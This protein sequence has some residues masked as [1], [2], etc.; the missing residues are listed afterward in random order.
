VLVV[1]VSAVV[2]L[3][4]FPFAPLFVPLGRAFAAR[5]RPV[6]LFFVPPRP[7]VSLPPV[8]SLKLLVAPF[9]V[10]P[11]LSYTLPAQ[12]FSAPPPNVCAALLGRV[13]VLPV[14]FGMLLAVLSFE[15]PAAPFSEPLEPFVSA[16]VA[17][18][19]PRH[20]IGA[21]S[22]SKKCWPHQLQ[23][24]ITAVQISRVLSH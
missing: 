10:P 8:V 13:F 20:W 18:Y 24:K 5:S 15:L 4:Q 9:F 22:G 14:V 1:L 21:G 3:S 11:G 7:C 23:V 2:L 16:L 17:A 19:E 6:G 12:L